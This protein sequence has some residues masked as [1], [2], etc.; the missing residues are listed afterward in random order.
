MVWEDR[1]DRKVSETNDQNQRLLVFPGGMRDNVDEEPIITAAREAYEETGELIS[2]KT[3]DQLTDKSNKKVIWIPDSKYALFIHELINDL[4]Q[5]I[6]EE[7]NKLPRGETGGPLKKEVEIV[8]LHWVQ[9][10]DLY[11]N[12]FYNFQPFTR[13]IITIMKQLESMPIIFKN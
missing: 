7:F 9:A 4:D 11:K 13:N 3:M 8:G 5:N 1:K 6:V 2:R 12:R 10:I